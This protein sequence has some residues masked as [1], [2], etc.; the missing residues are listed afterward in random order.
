MFSF[1]LTWQVLSRAIHPR[2]NDPVAGEGVNGR[3]MGCFSI[4]LS[5]ELGSRQPFRQTV[6]SPQRTLATNQDFYFRSKLL[7]GFLIVG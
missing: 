6:T 7:S 1:G 4:T 5:T 3:E 2:G